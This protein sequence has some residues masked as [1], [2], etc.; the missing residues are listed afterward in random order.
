MV[1]EGVTDE[2]VARRSQVSEQTYDRWRHQFGGRVSGVAASS[3]S[4]RGSISDGS[5]PH[6]HDVTLDGLDE[7]LR[8]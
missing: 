8:Q 3:L 6:P 1:G 4:D 2:E 7:A 5:T